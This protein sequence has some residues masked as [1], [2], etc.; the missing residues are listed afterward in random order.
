V[1]VPQ[2]RSFLLVADLG[3]M[4]R[5]AQESFIDLSA[6]SRRISQLEREFGAPLFTRSGKAL[7]LTD[8]GRAV[9]PRI[10]EAVAQL[11]AALRV[12]AP[13]SPTN[14]L[15]IL[16]PSMVGPR[17]RRRLSEAASRASCT[18]EF[19]LTRNEHSWE[20]LRN[21]EASFAV[22]LSGRSAPDNRPDTEASFVHLA[23]DRVLVAANAAATAHL[24]D[25][26]D[27]RDLAQLKYVTS[28]NATAPTFYGQL[29]AA[30]GWAGV[31]TRVELPHHDVTYISNIV[32][33]EAAFAF[34]PDDPS[35]PAHRSVA[36][37]EG[38]RL[39]EPVGMTPSLYTQL[40]WIDDVVTAPERAFLRALADVLA[41]EGGERPPGATTA[42]V[43]SPAPDAP[44]P[45]RVP[46]A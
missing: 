21:G 35:H 15:S 29:N 13:D 16:L 46:L 34:V 28:D 2:L 41:E 44:R 22:I 25:A 36:E 32:G 30:L 8:Q 42:A 6:M 17:V 33:T 26:V 19:L 45:Q 38:I 4:T 23:R 12:S 9:L 27:L 14:A 18:I 24:P 5:A 3:S 7:V 43:R 11:D 20:R 37:E 10:R 39:L 1:N 31:R 40:A